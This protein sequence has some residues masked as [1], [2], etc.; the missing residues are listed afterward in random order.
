MRVVP[1]PRIFYWARAIAAG[2]AVGLSNVEFARLIGHDPGYRWRLAALHD[3]CW[4]AHDY[5][6][7]AAIPWL[8]SLNIRCYILRGNLHAITEIRKQIQAAHRARP[9]IG[10]WMLLGD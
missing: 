5:L 1:Y 8:L 7:K 6:G 4:I 2:R 9:W 10:E 3:A